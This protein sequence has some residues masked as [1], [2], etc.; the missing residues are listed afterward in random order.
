MGTSKAHINFGP[1]VLLIFI[2]HSNDTNAE[3]EAFLDIEREL[4]RELEN[5]LIAIRY[6]SAFRVLKM[7]EWNCDAPLGVGGQQESVTPYLKR[8]NIALFVFKERIGKVTWDELLALRNRIEDRI[9]V[10]AIFPKTAPNMNL[11]D[12]EAVGNWLELLRKKVELTADWNSDGATSI[13]LGPCATE[14]GNCIGI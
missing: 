5:I 12:P 1:D 14:S 9:P 6:S 10:I 4:Q 13:K 11:N 7:W 8:A 3:V 2:G